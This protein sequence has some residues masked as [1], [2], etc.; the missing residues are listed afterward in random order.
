MKGFKFQITLQVI[1]RNEIQKGET[2]S[3]QLISFNSKTQTQKKIR[4]RL[5]NLKKK[6]LHNISIK[7]FLI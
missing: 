6:W 5:I 7:V 4:C 1:F 3:L 2:N